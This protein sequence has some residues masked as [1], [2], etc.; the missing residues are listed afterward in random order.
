MSDS[1][2]IAY[3]DAAAKISSSHEQSRVMTDLIKGRELSDEMV[4]Y[5][6]DMAREIDNSTSRSQVMDL[7]LDR[8]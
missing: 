5:A 2:I 6:F 1:E 3:I 8:L 4:R 7:L